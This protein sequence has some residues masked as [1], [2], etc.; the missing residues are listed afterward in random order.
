MSV[1]GVT[2]E[3]VSILGNRLTKGSPQVTIGSH[4]EE[5]QFLSP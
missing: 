4:V 2:F 3:N 5:V 1:R